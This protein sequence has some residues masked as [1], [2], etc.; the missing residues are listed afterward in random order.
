MFWGR[1]SS[2][3][4]AGDALTAVQA[5]MAILRPMPSYVDPRRVAF[6]L[7]DGVPTLTLTGVEVTTTEGWSLLNRQTLVV[8]DGPGDEGLLVRRLDDDG[9]DLA[10][11]GWDDTVASRG[12][13]D[14]A[15]SDVRFTAAVVG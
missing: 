1:E 7:V 11:A 4:L 13:V 8:V 14:V 5:T 12:L 2:Y 9:A 10:P 15:A 6:A 3:S